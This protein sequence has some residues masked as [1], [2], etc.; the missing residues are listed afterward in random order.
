M[1]AHGLSQ[2]IKAATPLLKAMEYEVRNSTENPFGFS[3]S[4]L[5]LLCD[6]FTLGFTNIIRF[7]PIFKVN[8]IFGLIPVTLIN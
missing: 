5:T 2:K 7:A 3:T 8:G 4:N 1:D 6:V